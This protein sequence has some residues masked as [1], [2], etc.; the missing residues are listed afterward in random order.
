MAWMFTKD[1][2]YSAVA[3]GL[4]DELMVRAR[5][6]EDLVKLRIKM[7]L[8]KVSPIIE[9]KAPADYR[10]RIV[11]SKAG[12]SDYV[13]KAILDIDYGNFKES[14]PIRRQR[15]YLRLWFIMKDAQDQEAG[16][17]RSID[18]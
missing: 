18:L 11:C 9:T 5:F 3:T 8:K 14:L 6:R 12:F 15:L 7:G 10:Y 4:N 13:K 17:P 1:G 16:L 2:F